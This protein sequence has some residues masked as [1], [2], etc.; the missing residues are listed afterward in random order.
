MAFAIP[1]IIVGSISLANNAKGGNVSAAA[2]DV[3]GL[4]VDVVAALIPGVPG[5]AGLAIAL[6]RKGAEVVGS[7]GTEFFRGALVASNALVHS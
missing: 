7:K 3:G 5:G 1:G 6:S 4:I 2:V